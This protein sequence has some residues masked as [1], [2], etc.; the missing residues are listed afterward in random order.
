MLYNSTRAIENAHAGVLTHSA[1]RVQSRS[2]S[3]Q[4]VLDLPESAIAALQVDRAEIGRELRL[5][6]AV[7]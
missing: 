2:M 6:A 5:A 4:V 3:K 7:K 1:Q